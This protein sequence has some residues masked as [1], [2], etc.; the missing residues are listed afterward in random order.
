MAEFPFDIASLSRFSTRKQQRETIERLADGSVGRH[1]RH[2]PVGPSPD[3]RFHKP[4]PGNP[5]R[6]AAVRRR[7][8]GA[9]QGVSPHRRRADDD[10][11]SHPAHAAL[12]PDGHPRHIESRNARRR[13]DWRSRRAWRG[14]TP[15]WFANAVLRELNRGGQIFFVHNR[16]ND[17]KILARR[18][19]EIVPEA[20]IGIA[21]RSDVGARAGASDARLRQ[22]SPR[23]AACHHDRGERIGYSQR[24]HDLHRRGRPLWPGRSPSTPRPRGALQAPGVLLPS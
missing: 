8:E 11:H 1:H 17:I 9:A 14:S 13:T 10:G 6:G 23:P 12:G 20:R 2:A 4:R 3:V 21:Q 22:S 7:G 5:R 19:R 15:T 18:L 24:Q 16:V